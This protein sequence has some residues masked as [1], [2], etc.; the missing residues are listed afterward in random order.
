MHWVSIIKKHMKVLYVVMK[1]RIYS[2]VSLSVVDVK[3][4]WNTASGPKFSSGEKG[5]NWVSIWCRW[6]TK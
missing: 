5:K 1:V 3:S 6:H 2:D 4:D